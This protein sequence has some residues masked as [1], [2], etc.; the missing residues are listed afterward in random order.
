M[1]FVGLFGYIFYYIFYCILNIVWC[2]SFD[3]DKLLQQIKCFVANE[4]K[5]RHFAKIV[6]YTDPLISLMI[7]PSSMGIAVCLKCSI[8]DKKIG[9]L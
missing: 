6:L 1:A 2:C 7:F 8:S 4:V 3:V 9:F 5:L